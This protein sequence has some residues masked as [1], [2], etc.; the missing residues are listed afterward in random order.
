MFDIDEN[1]FLWLKDNVMRNKFT[2]FLAIFLAVGAIVPMSSFAARGSL[3]APKLL[4]LYLGWQ[5]NEADSQKLADWDL[6]V[7]DMDMQWQAPQ[8]MR[9]LKL[10]NPKIKLLAYVSAGELAASRGQ[11]DPTSP[12]YH[13]WQRADENFFMHSSGGARLS[14]WPGSYLMNATDAG[15]KVA[16]Q[17]WADALP[18][19]IGSELMS[20]GLWDGVFLDA[21][22]S[23]I[24]YFFGRDIDIDGNGKADS[25]A[26]VNAAWKSGMS[27]LIGNVRKVVGKNGL[28]MVNSSSAYS[29]QVNGVLFEN[30]PRFGWA[31]PFKELQSA[32]ATNVAPSISAINTNT[33]NNEQ[34]E[35]YRLMRYGLASALMADAYYSFDA[36]D[37]GHQRTWWY[38]E[39]DAGLGVSRGSAVRL[40][41]TGNDGASGVW[42]RSFDGGLALVNSDSKPHKVDLP[43][44]FEKLHGTQDGGVNSGDLVRSISVPAEDGLVLLGR[45][46]SDE[47]KNSAFTNG[48]FQAVYS[49]DGVQQRNGFFAQRTEL[50]GGARII[51]ADLTHNGSEDAVSAL[52]GAVRVTADGKATVFYPFGSGYKG[53][54]SLAVGNTNHDPALE[55]VVGRDKAGPSDVR[56]Y[57]SSGR[58]IARWVAYNPAFS[59]GA[60]VG[61]GDLDGDGLREVVTGAGPGGGP[62]IRIF[63][64]DGSV[65][66]GSFFAFNEQE[67]GGVSVA[68]GDVDGDGKDEIVVGS[69]EGAVPRVRV[70]DFRGTLEHEFYLGSKPL[71]GGLEVSVSDVYGDARKEILVSGLSV[72]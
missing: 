34:P 64:T 38:D 3:A 31:A 27:R 25:S 42:M 49:A 72:F 1:R 13:L 19:F 67:R 35:D 60:R 33:D 41:A 11:G 66:G 14:W 53:K 2:Y 57:S 20:T 24:T 61:I 4:N 26:G 43:G 21:A 12:S 51:L 8:Q 46:E 9:L 29:S 28:I 47:I 15:P 40:V 18:E 63:K 52:N 62:H 16:G 23:D 55:I 50:P 39:Y 30:F 69:G 44:V 59:G 58:E 45:T 48:S 32:V 6:V 5:I 36:G 10:L 7:L 17:R 56:V 68:V 71:L 70:F 37:R 22:F 54:L 65:W